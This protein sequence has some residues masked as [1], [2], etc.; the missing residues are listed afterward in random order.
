MIERIIFRG[1]AWGVITYFGAIQAIDN[2]RKQVN[3]IISK[4]VRLHGL[5]AGSLALLLY[6]LRFSEK[7]MCDLYEQYAEQSRENL[8]KVRSGNILNITGLN[9]KLLKEILKDYPDAY[10][11][12]NEAN[13]RIG[14]TTKKGFR[15]V[16]DFRSNLHLAN[17]LMCSFHIPC[18]SNFDANIDGERALDGGIGFDAAL[19]IESNREKSLII[20]AS[21]P[22]SHINFDMTT[23]FLVVPPPG[24][25]HNH[26]LALG[27][28]RTTDALRN[29]SFNDE[30][31]AQYYTNP[32]RDPRNSVW[33]LV[34]H[35]QSNK[36]S[37]DELKQEIG[38]ST[39]NATCL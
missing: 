17:V 34:Q 5:S 9:I 25:L 4:D 30:N 19:F 39:L 8:L 16:K 36:T 32:L 27:Y 3:S 33:W 29:R 2:E 28:N 23:L 12:M 35:N 24:F 10:I 22:E 38:V 20:G 18:L 1:A 15:F 31:V 21:H 7:K 11:R 26:Y 6:V 37:Y 14:V 13:V